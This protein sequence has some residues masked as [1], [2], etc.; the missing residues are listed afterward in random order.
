MAPIR[1][2]AR[3]FALA[4]L[5]RLAVGEYVWPNEQTDELESHLYEGAFASLVDGCDANFTEFGR[6][7]GAEWLRTAYHDMATADVLAGTGGM[8]GSLA[9]ETDRA[10]NTGDGLPATVFT[11]MSQQTMR[12]SMPDLLAMLAVL[13]VGACSKGNI[14]IPLR[15]GRV[16]AA[17]AGPLGVPE[18]QQDLASHTASFQRQGFN[19][20][21]MIGL[22]ACGH[23]IGGVHGI[24]FPEIV[25]V[26]NNS[27]G[28]STNA[29][30]TQTFD[31][32]SKNLENTIAKE[33]VANVSQNPLAFGPNVT[34]RSDFRIFNAD[35]GEVINKMADSIDYFLSTCS[36]LLER[37]L[38]TVPRGVVLGE[39]I[40]P[41]LI[42]PMKLSIEIGTDGNMIVS[43]K[44]RVS[45]TLIASQDSQ[46]IL[47]FVP[48]SGEACSAT[49][50][51]PTAVAS[52]NSEL[53]CGFTN[54][55]PLWK[56]Y[57]F[58]ATVP[59]EHGISSFLVEI[60]DPSGTSTTYDNGGH[61]F[62][63]SDAIPPQL[64]KSG[65]SFSSNNGRT[66]NLTVAVLNDERFTNISLVVPEADD[67]NSKLAAW[68]PTVTPM[69]RSQAVAGTNYTLYTAVHTTGSL[70][71][72]GAHPYDIVA[73]GPEGTVISKYN[74]WSDV[75]LV[76]P[77]AI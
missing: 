2:I 44:I 8:D 25:S 11:V 47:H 34:T 54:C 18:P 42:K 37:M 41:V 55:G 7:I 56:Y 52:Y 46:L 77:A 12:S 30:H 23:S 31:T 75:P 67:P 76:L 72:N 16:S 17:G 21:E 6:N 19:V 68:S 32:T 13:A 39:P 35:G 50:P 29:D 63:L 65:V 36:N 64:S 71:F 14:I 61:G 66:L 51:C 62:P 49:E 15:P 1:S 38:N 40:A 9:L 33:F 26:N 28:N 3:A 45:E 4:G 73:A 70:R 43:G 27:T 59:I 60:S 5:V 58:H 57:D 22:V 20:Q 48:R 10:E 24:D 74:S 69:V 53:G